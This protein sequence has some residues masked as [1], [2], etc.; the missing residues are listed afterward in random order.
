[1]TGLRNSNS[2]LSD[3]GLGNDAKYP[4]CLAFGAL[5]VRSILRHEGSNHPIGV[6]VGFE[7]GDCLR[8]GELTRAGFAA[9][10]KPML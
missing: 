4:L 9:N 5:A 8:I 3:E 7:D 10:R 6:V 2:L 1:M